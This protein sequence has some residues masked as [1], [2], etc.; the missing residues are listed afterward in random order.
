MFLS[1]K[2]IHYI[3]ELLSKIKL[4][5]NFKSENIYLGTSFYIIKIFKNI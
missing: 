2:K 1:F 4:T 3:E 5:L